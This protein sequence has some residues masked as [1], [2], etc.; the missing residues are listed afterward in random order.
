MVILFFG[1]VSRLFLFGVSCG[2]FGGEIVLSAL[3]FI[4]E[5]EIPQTGQEEKD[6]EEHEEGRGDV[7]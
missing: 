5:S 6:R 1:L 3:E 4:L 2:S 7:D